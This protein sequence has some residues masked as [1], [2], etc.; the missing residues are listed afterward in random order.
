MIFPAK[1]SQREARYA[2]IPGAWPV[3]GPDA[4]RDLA[5]LLV[6]TVHVAPVAPPPTATFGHPA[7]AGEFGVQL[8]FYPVP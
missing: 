4:L 1:P 5:F 2:P 3:P 6:L 8:F 7:Q